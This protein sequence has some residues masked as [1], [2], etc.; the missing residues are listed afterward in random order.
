MKVH[1]VKSG[2]DTILYYARS[3]RIGKKTTCKN[4]R[5]FDTSRPPRRQ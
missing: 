5:K 2:N 3:I 4:I 1:A